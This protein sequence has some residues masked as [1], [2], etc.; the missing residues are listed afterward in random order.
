MA[1]SQRKIQKHIYGRNSRL[2]IFYISYFDI[3]FKEERFFMNIVRPLNSG[4]LWVLK[5]C[6]LL[7]GVRIWEVV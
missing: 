1:A 6:P 7:R 3:I 4:H 5:M 2:H